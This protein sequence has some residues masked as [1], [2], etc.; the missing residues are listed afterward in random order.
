MQ[1]HGPDVEGCNCQWTELDED[2]S[3]CDCCGAEADEPCERTTPLTEEEEEEMDEMPMIEKKVHPDVE[4]IKKSGDDEK[5]Y[6][7][8][9]TR[10]AGEGKYFV[11]SDIKSSSGGVQ[12]ETTFEASACTKRQWIEHHKK[13]WKG[14]IDANGLVFEDAPDLRLLDVKVI[15]GCL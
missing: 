12:A 14:Y 13:W 2:S 3:K 5:L 15:G 1:E 7:M 6:V 11:F 4:V 10:G 8:K 9:A